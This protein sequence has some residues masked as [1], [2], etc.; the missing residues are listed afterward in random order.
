[1]P[2]ESHIA[3]G[4]EDAA[5]IGHLAQQIGIEPGILVRIAAHALADHIRQHGTLTLPVRIATPQTQ[6]INGKGPHNILSGPWSS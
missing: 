2:Q 4:A 5:V 6:Q 3:I 1:M